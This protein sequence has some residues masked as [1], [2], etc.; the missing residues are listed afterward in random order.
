MDKEIT[1]PSRSEWES[2]KNDHLVGK[3]YT[4]FLAAWVEAF[5]EQFLSGA[6]IEGKTQEELVLD[7]IRAQ[8]KATIF[9]ELL[10]LSY[11]EVCVMMEVN[12]IEEK[13]T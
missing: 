3:F 9:N 8:T 10:N 1:V 7:N 13:D 4:G 12:P 5:L 6:L 11:D 2:W